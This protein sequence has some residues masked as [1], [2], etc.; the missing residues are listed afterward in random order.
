MLNRRPIS[1]PELEEGRENHEQ[2][3]V[4]SIIGLSMMEEQ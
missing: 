1:I 4:F 2:A 3:L